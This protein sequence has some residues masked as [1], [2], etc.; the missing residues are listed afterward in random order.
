MDECRFDNWTKMFGGILDRRTALKQVAGAGVALMALAR[1]ELGLAQDEEVGIEG[2]RLSGESCDRHKQCCSNKCKG[3]KRRRRRRNE[4]DRRR[5]RRREDRSGTCR[6]LG[7]GANCNKDAACCRGRCDPNERRC[8]CV[9]P[10][11]ICTKDDD[12]C[13]GSCQADDQ[14]NRFCKT[15]SRR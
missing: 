5:R 10:N 6:C 9:P 3:R 7:N 14:G 15:K 1:V 11:D 12:C 2:C 8:R 4:D 13:R